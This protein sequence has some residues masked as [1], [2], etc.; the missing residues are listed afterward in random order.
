MESVRIEPAVADDVGLILAMITELAEY[1]GY[2]D[3]VQAT[4][5]LLAESLFGKRSF[6]KVLIAYRE[7]QPVGYMVYC[8]KFATYTARNEIYLQDLYV[9]EEA[10]GSGLGMAFMTKLAEVARREKAS[11]IEWFVDKNNTQALSFYEGLGAKVI[12]GISVVRLD[13]QR[14]NELG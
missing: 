12:D 7:E 3:E 5:E 14:L 1:E 11:R 6:A 4:E 10:R 8:P 2:S 13:G 9:R